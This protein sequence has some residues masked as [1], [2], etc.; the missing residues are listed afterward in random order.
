MRAP[1]WAKSRS[2]AQFGG[3]FTHHNR[4]VTTLTHPC[5]RRPKA[6]CRGSPWGISPTMLWQKAHPRLN[7]RAR[8]FRIRPSRFLNLLVFS[9]LGARCNSQQSFCDTVT[10]VQTHP[11][12]AV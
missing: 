10:I 2:P 1:V 7:G 5:D 9:R 3:D 12:E 6:L 4:L 8:V 11:S